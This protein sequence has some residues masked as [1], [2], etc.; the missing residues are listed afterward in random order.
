M[1]N[2]LQNNNTH[3]YVVICKLCLSLLTKIAIILENWYFIN[4][5]RLIILIC[6]YA[7]LCD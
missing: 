7:E 3:K 4:Y 1:C 6:H 5:L 2:F